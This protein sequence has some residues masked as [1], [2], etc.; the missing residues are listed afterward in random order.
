MFEAVPVIPMQVVMFAAQMTAGGHLQM[1]KLPGIMQL[2]DQPL[3]S[4][5]HPQCCLCTFPGQHLG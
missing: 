1:L 4:Q 3:P 2:Q 5:Y